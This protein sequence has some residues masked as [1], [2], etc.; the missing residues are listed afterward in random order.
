M[1]VESG[2]FEDEVRR[3]A[4]ELWP[5]GEFGGATAVDGRQRDGI[6]ETEDQIHC[7]ECTIS[8]GRDKAIEDG[9]KL[10]KLTKKLALKSKFVRGLVCHEARAYS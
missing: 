3:I 2:Q 1:T 5:S 4:R 10:D 9:A 6:F 7:I 8:R